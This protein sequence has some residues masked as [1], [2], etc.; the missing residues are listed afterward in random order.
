MNKQPKTSPKQKS[1]G[2]NGFT[3]E[4]YQTFKKELTPILLKLFQKIDKEGTLPKSLYEAALPEYQNQ[5][6]YRK[7]KL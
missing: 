4:L 2:L 7:L 6:Y 3:E 1:P 5:R